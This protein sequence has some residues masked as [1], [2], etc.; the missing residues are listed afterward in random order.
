MAEAQQLD[1]LS[2]VP[3][4]EI[5]P[6]RFA[7]Q[8]RNPPTSLGSEQPAEWDSYWLASLADSGIHG[9][10]ALRSGSW[11]V[12]TPQLGHPT[13]LKAI[14]AKILAHDG[15]SRKPPVHGEEIA[16]Y[17]GGALLAG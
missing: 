9:L 17:G 6:S 12:P 15:D 8:G 16:L 10:R 2:L 14:M 1:K 4:I 5:V 3:V 11:H 13:T 7:A